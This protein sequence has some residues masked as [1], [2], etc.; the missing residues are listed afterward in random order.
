[1]RSLVIVE[2][3]RVVE[4][5]THPEARAD[6]LRRQE[7]AE[8]FPVAL[9]VLPAAVRTHLRAVYDVVRVIDDLGDDAGTRA[10]GGRAG[11]VRAPTWPRS[12]TGRRP[13]PGAARAGARGAG[14]PA[15]STG[16]S[17]TLVEANL[18]DQTRHPLPR[19]TGSCW[20][21]ARCPRTRSAGWCCRCSASS[22]PARVGCPTGSAPRC[23]CSSTGR[24]SPRT[25]RAGPGLPAGRGPGPVRGRRGRPRR[26]GASPAV[27]A[28][29]RVRDRA[30][31]GAARRRR[32]ARRHAARL[33]P[34]GGGRL[35]RRRAGRGRRAAPPRRRRAGRHRRGLDAGTVRHA[36]SALVRGRATL[37]GGGVPA[38][39]SARL[40]PVEDA[41]EVCDAI[42]RERGR[43]LLL[44]HPA[45]A[46]GQA[47]RA[48]RASTRWP[49]AST[50]SATATWPPVA[51]Q[52]AALARLRAALARPRRDPDD[53]VLVAVADA[54]R[55]L[56][57]PAGRVRRAR[58]RRRDGRDRAAA[59]RR[60]TSSSTYCRCVAGSV[61]RLCL[62]VFGSR[63]DPAA[64]PVRRRAR[65]RPAAD[66]HPAR[67]PRGPAATA[68]ST[69]RPRTRPRSASTLG[70]T[71]PARWSTRTARWPR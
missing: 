7:S 6:R 47:R 70:S 17:P 53:P 10:T 13:R 44:R 12:G 61:G 33:G 46:A 39:P 65:H 24:T 56:P 29:G 34:A 60:S 68:G 55:P 43:Q 32:A 15:W 4:G 27:R 59:T 25:S 19:R 21:T 51:Q 40:D 30:G 52:A 11:G 37:P 71:T 63:P 69:C 3:E 36:L 8:N 42:T 22:T 49:G 67:H 23:S 45:A 57:D 66:Q 48:V 58:R 41:Y 18:R 16:R 20:G 1:M 5:P 28:A 9:R 54:A 35:R 31:R 62:G 26:A 14:V 38:R 50:T 2:G 64:R